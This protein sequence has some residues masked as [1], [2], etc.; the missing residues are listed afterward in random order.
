MFTLADISVDQ[1]VIFSL[2]FARVA[3]I[4]AFLPLLGG[5]YVPTHIK[6]GI[7]LVISILV[8]PVVGG[9]DINIPKGLYDYSILFVREVMIGLVIGYVS[10]LIF[11]GVQYA[12]S[13][14]DLQIG[15]TMIEIIDP[16]TEASITVIGHFKTLVFTMVFLVIG[17]H[18]YFIRVIGDSFEQIMLDNASLSFNLISSEL[19]NLTANIFVI[20]I[21]L[22]AP[23][24]ITLVITTISLG[25]IAR[26]IPQ[27]NVFI[28]GLP[29][30]ISV[31]LAVMVIS[32]PLLYRIF[33]YLV[34]G[35]LESTYRM[36]MIMG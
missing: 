16:E 4:I 8:F 1:F 12:G 35:L 10:S 13:I 18:Y 5:A 6:A 14:I 34:Q 22:S 17:A 23:V 24:L 9:Y 32:L 28:V 27:I 30:Q 29:L 3:S 11:M 19:V 15:F 2:V 26:V 36:L 31:G 21:K 20:A 25:I 7:A 33:E